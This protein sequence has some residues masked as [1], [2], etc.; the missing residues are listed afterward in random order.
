MLGLD[1]CNSQRSSRSATLPCW[2]AVVV[3]S[4]TLLRGF[5]RTT[6]NMCRIFRR[7]CFLSKSTLRYAVLNSHHRPMPSPTCSDCRLLELQWRLSTHRRHFLQH[8]WLG[9]CSQPCWQHDHQ[10]SSMSAMGA[11]HTPHESIR[12]CGQ[13]QPSSALPTRFRSLSRHPNV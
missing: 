8:F 1:G 13:C 2:L 12:L 4:Y 3:H 9:V 10:R 5:T 11:D 7:T 6:H